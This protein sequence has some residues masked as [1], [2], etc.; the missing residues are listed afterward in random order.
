MAETQ[1]IGRKDV[2]VVNVN[3]NAGSIRR[4][5]I[6]GAQ[7][8][9]GTILNKARAISNKVKVLMPKVTVVPSEEGGIKEFTFNAPF[10][11][12]EKGD[13]QESGKVFLAQSGGW[14][15]LT[16][17]AIDGETGEEVLTN[18]GNIRQTRLLLNLNGGSEGFTHKVSYTLMV[19]ASPLTDKDFERMGE[20]GT[21]IHNE[22]E[23]GEASS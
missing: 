8:K 9:F 13:F 3:A 21:L 11:I 1:S 17:P 23:G 10:Q 4:R 22:E 20:N 16:I 14:K 18:G 6:S 5:V 7:V 19:M 12:V 15:A 2:G